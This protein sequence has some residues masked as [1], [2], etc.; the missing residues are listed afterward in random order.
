MSAAIIPLPGAATASVTR[1]K[2]PPGR[3][4]KNVA[5]IN[6]GRYARDR[7]LVAME[8]AAAL[9]AKARAIREHALGYVEGY[10]SER[11]REAIHLEAQARVLRGSMV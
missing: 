10:V 6:R 9:E 5:S 8:H 11:L 1:S 7:R 3:P 4:P 2:L